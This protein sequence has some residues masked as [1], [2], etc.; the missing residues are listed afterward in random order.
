MT[1]NENIEVIN[2][3]TRLSFESLLPEDDNNEMT[4]YHIAHDI[5]IAYISQEKH[6]NVESFVQ[7]YKKVIE[8]VY[9]LLAQSRAH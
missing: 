3:P 2:L 1:E 4:L 9:N 6:S 7:A 5:A 8:Q